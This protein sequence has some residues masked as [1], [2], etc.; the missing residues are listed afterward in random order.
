[1]RAP[2]QRR[3]GDLAGPAQRPNPYE[4]QR[5]H[6]RE[7][8]HEERGGRAEAKPALGRAPRAAPPRASPG[9]PGQARPSTRRGY[10]HGEGPPDL[11]ERF[12]SRAVTEGIWGV[13]P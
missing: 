4:L 10:G 2:I 7:D 1:M 13:D 8:I 12:G 9:K 11:Q 5:D 3:Q 6:M